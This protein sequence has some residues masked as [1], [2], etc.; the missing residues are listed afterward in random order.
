M[1]IFEPITVSGV[2]ADQVVSSG[3]TDPLVRAINTDGSSVA[4]A[5][6]VYLRIATT[7]RPEFA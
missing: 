4:A 2:V 5:A 6:T 3:A 1:G 7:Y